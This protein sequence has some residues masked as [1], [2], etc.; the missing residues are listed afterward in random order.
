MAD[1]CPCLKSL[2]EAKMK[3]FGLIPLTEEISKHPSIDSVLWLF[4]FTDMQIVN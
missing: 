2:P 3:H 1:F 4:S